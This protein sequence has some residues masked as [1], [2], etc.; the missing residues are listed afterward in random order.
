MATEDK[1]IWTIDIF[2][3][4]CESKY[5]WTAYAKEGVS[6]ADGEDYT[7]SPIGVYSTKAEAK[8]EAKKFVK[9]RA[10]AKRRLVER[11]TVEV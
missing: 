3:R 9:K 6:T 7:M 10:D 11:Y 4:G 5:R 8:R 2:Y 1:E